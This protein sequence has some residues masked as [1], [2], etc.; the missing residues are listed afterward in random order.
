MMTRTVRRKRLRL[1]L[2]LQGE[3]VGPVQCMVALLETYC[4][5]SGLELGG[6]QCAVM[7]GQEFNEYL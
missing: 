6:W 4:G 7:D 2:S 5:Q 3:S 1:S